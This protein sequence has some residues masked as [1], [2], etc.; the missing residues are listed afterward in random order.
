MSG[1]WEKDGDNI[2]VHLTGPKGEKTSGTY[3]IHEDGS[4]S[5]EAFG[6]ALRKRN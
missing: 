3:L 4:L 5:T 2:I 6:S 1:T